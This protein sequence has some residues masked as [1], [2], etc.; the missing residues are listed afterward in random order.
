MS[1]NVDVFH[2]ARRTDALPAKS[3]M[4][5]KTRQATFGPVL[6]GC[7]CNVPDWMQC[8]NPHNA[9]SVSPKLA[10]DNALNYDPF[11]GEYHAWN[12]RVRRD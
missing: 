7:Q 8:G 6:T 3:P 1:A 9:R 4:A 5:E 11:R 2:Y 10:D 12:L